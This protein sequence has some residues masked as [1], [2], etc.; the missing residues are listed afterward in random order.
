MQ[1]S[2]SNH[3]GGIKTS[4]QLTAAGKHNERAYSREKENIY[5]LE[6]E[7]KSKEHNEHL[8]GSGS[9]YRDV[10][11]VYKDEFDKAIRDYNQ[12]QEREDRQKGDWRDYFNEVSNSPKQN[13]AVEMIIQVGSKED[14]QG[15]DVNTQK[16]AIN[17]LMEQ[18]L[19]YLEKNLPDFKIAS[20][21]VHYDESSPHLHVIGVPTK[22]DYVKGQEVRVSQ[23]NVFNK[24]SMKEHLQKGMRDQAERYLKERFKDIELK[25]KEQGRKFSKS[26]GAYKEHMEKT[27]QVERELKEKTKALEKVRD[28]KSKKDD[29][30]EYGNPRDRTFFGN[31]KSNSESARNIAKELNNQKEF[32]KHI[33]SLAKENAELKGY[34]ERLNEDYDN[35]N[36]VYREQQKELERLKEIER[37]REQERPKEQVR[38]QEHER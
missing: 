2:Y 35:L 8:R 21:I 28:Y 14:W 9:V 16:E 3:I 33:N 6:H 37:Q 30:R 1:V 17:P 26:V 5:R 25:E 20:A 18:Q 10:L 15:V 13:V 23:R 29:I 36:K 31:I 4:G 7:G 19:E 27:Q 32:S 22:R 34:N 11:K 24:D 38:E 12:K